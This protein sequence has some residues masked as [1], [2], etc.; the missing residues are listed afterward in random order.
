MPITLQP[1]F[2]LH[3]RPYRETSLL[4]ELFTR[5][6]GRLSIMARGIR[7]ARS[8]AAALL[9]PF[10]PLLI[11]CQG[12]NELQTLTQAEP[13]GYLQVLSGKN[14]RCGFYLNELLMRLLPKHDSHAQL[15]EVY[16][17]TLGELNTISAEAAN[18]R[19]LRLFEKKL[20]VEIGYGL[21][22]MQEQ[23]FNNESRYRFDVEQGFQICVQGS[24]PGQPAPAG[25]FAGKT[26]NALLSE[27]FEDSQSLQEVKRLMRFVLATLLGRPL[28]SRR[29]FESV[30]LD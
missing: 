3:R 9:Q 4:I 14:L 25:V 19:A 30:T 15:F 11:S 29:L 13:D 2:V 24:K 6:H 1:A 23:R 10:T 27:S 5:D 20:L 18:E 8:S 26:L 12:K 22:S 28:E 21:P 17:Q 16:R 7:K